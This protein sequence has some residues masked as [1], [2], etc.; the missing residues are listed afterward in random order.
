LISVPA[1]GKLDEIETGHV[2]VHQSDA[3]IILII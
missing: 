2:D 3:I 1:A